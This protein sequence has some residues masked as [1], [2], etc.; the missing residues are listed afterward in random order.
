MRV[1]AEQARVLVTVKATPSPSE[2]YGDTVCVAGLRLDTPTPT[3]IRLYPIA[4]RWLEEGAQFKKYD[5]IQVE[6]RRRDADTRHESYSPTEDSIRVVGH[7]DDWEARQQV[8]QDV[9]RTTTCD[10]VEGTSGNRHD[11]PSLGLVPV[12]GTPRLT[13]AEHEPWTDEQVRKMMQRDIAS[14]SQLFDGG[15]RPPVLRAPRLKATYHYK[16]LKPSCPGHKGRNLDW[17]LTA[18]QNRFRHVTDDALKEM[19]REQF[20]DK[21]FSPQKETAFFMG[22]FE[23]AKMRDRFT[24]LGTH[25]PARAVGTR[26][27]LF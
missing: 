20:L 17:E 18:L 12:L 11:G 22:N 2:K 24:V 14:G 16:C 21:M 15:T 19:V 26:A 13:F 9:P 6:V 1:A 25:Y 23:L 10:L 27:T 5:I 3:W 4:F 7:L 8:F